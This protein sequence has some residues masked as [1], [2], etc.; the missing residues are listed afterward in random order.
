MKMQKLASITLI[1]IGAIWLLYAY[2]MRIANEA[3]AYSDAMQLES[4]L[5]EWAGRSASE[6]A[7]DEIFSDSDSL[8]LGGEAE[9]RSFRRMISDMIERCSVPGW[10]GVL[11]VITGVVTLAGSFCRKNRQTESGPLE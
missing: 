8:K 3:A 7:V 9:N 4:D 11:A 10:P 5:K 2:P 6:E 1:L